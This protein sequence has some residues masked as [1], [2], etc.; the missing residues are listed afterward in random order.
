MVLRIS[1]DRRGKN[2]IRLNNGKEVSECFFGI[3][4][5]LEK[6]IINIFDVLKCQ[7]YSYEFQPDIDTGYSLKMFI[8]NEMGVESHDQTIIIADR[9]SFQTLE[10]EKLLVKQCKRNVQ[11]VIFFNTKP[12]SYT[13]LTLPTKA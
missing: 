12:V 6:K 9:D 11:E 8:Q 1:A 3:Q 13:H 5:I 10:D 4:Q 7:K 2:K